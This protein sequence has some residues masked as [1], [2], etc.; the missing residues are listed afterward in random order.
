MEKW[1]DYYAVEAGH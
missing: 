1:N